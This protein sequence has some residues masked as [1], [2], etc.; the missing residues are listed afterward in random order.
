MRTTGKRS[1]VLYILLAAFIL[2]AAVLV[3]R[4]FMDGGKWAMQPYNYH[5]G[6]ENLGDITDRD[7]NLLAYTEDGVRKYNEDE[8][9]RRSL[10]HTVG[11]S[12]GMIST[13]VQ[14]TMRSKL[15]GYN[16]VTGV[17]NTVLSSIANNVKLT[18]DSNVNAAAYNALGERKGAVMVYD[19]TNGDIICKVSKPSYDP[20]NIPEDLQENEYY[21][22]V[23][24][25]EN[26]S[27]SFV[28]GSVFKLVTEAAAMEQW[29]DWQDK[30]YTCN[31]AV[32]LSGSNI[33]CL[34][35][36]GTINAYQAMGGSCNVYYA[37]LAN[38]LGAENLQ[39][40]AE[41]MGFNRSLSFGVISC[42]PSSINLT[43]VNNNQLG[44]SGVGQYTTQ[45]N[46]YHM[47]VLMGAIARGGTYVEPRLTTSSDLFGG[48]STD[49]RT[50]LSNSEATALK[51]IM[52]NTVEYYYGDWLFP[53]GMQ[54][55]A[56][57]GTAEI[58]GKSPT[59]WF[60]GFSANPSTPYAFIIMV[61]EGQSGMETAGNAAAAVMSAVKNNMQ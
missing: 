53:D 2:G 14:S 8:S 37:L 59:C 18:I 26:L 6:T 9:V 35:T 41:Q 54:V 30:Q 33:T 5:L 61:E 49:D 20:M 56:K 44:W 36:H 47:L 1:V 46:P 15:S 40:K 48:S 58:D 7:G 27:Q 60:A 31:G 4:I 25:D 17:N 52:R 19:Y 42:E 34:E 39:K 21:N 13:S 55:C 3:F 29:S 23:F 10:L 50:L 24:L 16:F 22:G 45:A 57:S 32:E 28:P 51:A 38:D 12:D 11:D 43:G